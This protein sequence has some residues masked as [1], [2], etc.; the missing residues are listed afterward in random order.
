MKLKSLVVRSVDYGPEKG[1]YKGEI[2]VEGEYGKITIFLTENDC[3]KFLGV[4]KQGVV[5]AAQDVA[6]KLTTE[7]MTTIPEPQK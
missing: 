3:T 7:V 2:E 6:S 4:I 1:Q 5:N